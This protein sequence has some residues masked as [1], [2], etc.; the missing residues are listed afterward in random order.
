[1]VESKI[2]QNDI[3]QLLA[4]LPLFD[5][6]QHEL[7]LQWQ[8]GHPIYSKDVERF[9][10]L[11][12]QLRCFDSNYTDKQARKFLN[13]IDSIQTLS[14]NEIGSM[15]TYC[16]R[17]ERFCDGHWNSLL[18]SGKVVKILKRLEVIQNINNVDIVE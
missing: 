4:F 14:L 13:Q 2:S 3:A 5:I 6:L 7:V 15:L 8:D 18:Q 10:K 12:S 11:V 1:M 17:S 9:F 16:A